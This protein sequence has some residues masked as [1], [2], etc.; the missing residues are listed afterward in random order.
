MKG[1]ELLH[2][3]AAAAQWRD[4][5]GGAEKNLSKSQISKIKR[6]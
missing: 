4:S 1:A 6:V 3:A 5:I 2:Q